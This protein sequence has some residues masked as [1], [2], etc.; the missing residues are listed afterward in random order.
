MERSIAPDGPYTSLSVGIAPQDNDG[1]VLLPGLLNLD[2]DA[3][4][5]NDS[6]TVGTT[7][8][9]FGRLRLNNAYGT[10]LLDL[11]LPVTTE[12]YAGS[13]FVT[14]P[15]DNCTIL[16][17]SDFA[18]SFLAGFPLVACNT[19]MNPSSTIYF[20]AG[21]ASA[22]APPASVSPP[23]LTKPGS[24]NNG[25]VDLT[26]NL[27]GPSGTTCLAIGGVGPASTN[28]NKQYLQ[29][30][31]GS[32]SYTDNPRGRATFGIYKSADQFIFLR[33]VF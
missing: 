27:N 1:I 19:A 21:Q 32:G 11:P 23:R 2:A 9:R 30:N 5:V 33:E 3:N 6:F 26:I 17:A 28:A 24:G 10:P 13:F 29:G 12:Y 16:A 14:N 8:I 15:Q 18:F 22:V 4:A 31:W 20:N 25:S 7:E